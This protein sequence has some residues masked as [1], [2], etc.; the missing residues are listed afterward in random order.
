MKCYK[1]GGTLTGSDKCPQCGAEVSLYKKAV[2]ASNAYYN[3]GLSKARIRDLSGAVESLKTSI[4]IDKNNIDARNLLGLVYCELG[5]VVEA[6]SEWV[7]SK[8]IMP[9]NNAAG[10]YIAQIQSSQNR[11]DMVTA[12]VK[13]YNMSL[14]YAKEGNIDMATIQ[15]KKIVSQNP[16]L[17]KAHQLLALIYINKKEYNRAR[18]LLNNVLK[19][20]RNN[21]L[22][23]LYLQ[24][25][26][27][28]IHSKKK[29][30]SQSSSGSFLPEKKERKALEDKPLSGNDVIMPHSSYK[31]PSNGAITVI[32]I[33]VGVA[34][35]AALI[36][37][38]VMPSRYKGI[39]EDYNTSLK[40]YSEQ[41]SSGN[42]ELNSLTQ[43]LSQVQA[44]KENLENELSKLSGDNGSNKLLSSVIDA[45]NYYI[46]N[47][48][49][50]AASNLID[51]DVSA[52]PTDTAK[53]LYNTIAEATMKNASND[54]YNK[55]TT[56]YRASNYTEAAENFVN[57]YKCDST[58]V[59][60]AYY[61]AK[62]YVALNQTEDAKKY[63][64]YIVD[65]FTTSGYYSEAN[66]YVTSH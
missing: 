52:L 18:R 34:I 37:F 51:V 1:C 22:A 54:F 14:K 15:L 61:A 45:A 2:M 12:T 38:L 4:M 27:D 59:D 55:G 5:D 11:F 60:A 64:Q 66:A 30:S 63:Y 65:G 58:K 28:A 43:Q 47:D 16:H 57:A 32:N 19:I 10:S 41:L 7:I 29:E 17:I 48:Y 53:R 3:L 36:W 8:N 21:T 42:V 50:Q 24:E 25:I 13:K 62:S 39:T 6:L 40:E 26:E 33:L 20:D 44:E 31:E 35:G 9:E 46:A 56:A 49:T 23:L